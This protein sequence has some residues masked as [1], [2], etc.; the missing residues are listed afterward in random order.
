M[1]TGRGAATIFANVALGD[2]ITPKALE[3]RP[4]GATVVV[5][6]VSVMSG[7]LAGRVGRHAIRQFYAP[8]LHYAQ[9]NRRF[10]PAPGPDTLAGMRRFLLVPLLIAVWSTP[11]FAQLSFEV[12]GARA[13]GMGGAFVAVADDSTAFHWNPAGLNRASPVGMTVGWDE[14]RFGN[15]SSPAMVGA[16][17]DSNKLTSVTT[18]PLGVSYGYFESARV[19][20]LQPD[21]TPVVEAL[22][23]HHVGVTVL[24]TLLDGLVVGTTV[25]YLRGRATTSNS[26]SLT[27]G[28]ALDEAM[29][30]AGPSDGAFDLDVGVMGEMGPVR[31]GLTMKNLLQPT[32]AGDAGFAIQLKRRV[33]AGISVVPADGV[34]LAFDM[35]LDTADP[36]VRRMMALGG[37]ARLGSSLTLRSGV[38]WSRDGE[39]RPIAALGTSLKVYKGLWLD[40]YATYSRS[41]DRGFGIALRAGS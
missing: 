33:R 13:L 37:E 2:T 20:G 24:Q 40:G 16:S 18:W 35:D 1:P 30:V 8:A 7:L 25:K 12:L 41:D 6:A 4:S 28:G 19:V 23:V 21:G 26:S 31:V 27:A 3:S 9:Q 39:R 34:T 10:L 38:R 22:R 17:R 11:A 36:L 15:S 32:F 14:L 5:A 29:K